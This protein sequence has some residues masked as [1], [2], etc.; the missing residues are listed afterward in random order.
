MIKARTDDEDTLKC[1]TTV[2]LQK[3][4][5]CLS[6]EYQFHFHQH[7]N[8][9]VCETG[10]QD[11]TQYHNMSKNMWMYVYNNQITKEAKS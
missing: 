6:I 5:S 7:A 1:F 4:V 9:A 11:E 8:S 2:Y 3:I 10:P